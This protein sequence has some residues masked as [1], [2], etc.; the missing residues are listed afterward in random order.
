M[1]LN[2]D[3]MDPKQRDCGDLYD[4]CSCGGNDCGCPYCYDCHACEE[5]EP[6]D[7]QVE[8]NA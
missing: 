2:I 3:P 6:E 4:C 1:C 5:C 7:E 8:N